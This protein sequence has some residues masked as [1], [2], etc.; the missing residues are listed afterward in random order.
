MRVLV[1]AVTVATAGLGAGVAAA[2][3]GPKNVGRCVQYCWG[4]R[5]DLTDPVALVTSCP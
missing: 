2:D 5:P 3:C 4:D 1:L